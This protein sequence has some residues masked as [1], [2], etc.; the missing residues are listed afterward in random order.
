[1]LHP[2]DG[3]VSQRCVLEVNENSADLASLRETPPL[4]A[5]SEAAS[6]IF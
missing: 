5:R 1:M 4:P 3:P 2:V 6:D